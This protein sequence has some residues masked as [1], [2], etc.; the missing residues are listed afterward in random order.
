MHQATAGADRRPSTADEEAGA[1]ATQDPAVTPA[2]HVVAPDP[3]FQI[4]S[5]FMAAKHLFVANEVGLFAALAHGP[6]RLDELA[7]V[8]GVARHRLRV[9]ADAMVALGLL[10]LHADQYQNGQVATAFLSG[11]TATD[12]RPFLL[13]WDQL[14]YPMWTG[15][16]DAV[17]TGRG[18]SPPV[19]TADQQRLY[20]EGVEAIQAEPA[21]ALPASYD[22]GQHQRLLD[23]GGG[24]GSWLLAVVQQYRHLRA[25][26]F[27]LPG[28]A[29]LAR[30]RLADQ[31][32][33]TRNIDVVDGDFFQDSIPAGH[34]VILIANV[35]HLFSSHRNKDLLRRVR[36][37]ATNGTRLLLADFWTDPT[38]TEP[39]FAALM[40]GE[41]LVI[42]GE[43]AVYSAQEIKNWLDDTGW[44][45][46]D[47]KPLV[48]PMSLI[49]AESV[50]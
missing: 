46:I 17:R 47:R 8:T 40:A 18:Q 38:H 20:S 4:A 35:M 15:F 26:L 3:I 2:G 27:E 7:A 1:P 29:A 48:G 13:F 36:A 32:L 34:D 39:I 22:F 9:L 11:H 42:T 28:A 24:T 50:G 43:G 25:T 45:L 30:R 41:F 14:S 6:S 5:G 49:V 37:S 23:L 44:R 31:Q 12:L 16:A 10:E 21:H 33:L 19:L